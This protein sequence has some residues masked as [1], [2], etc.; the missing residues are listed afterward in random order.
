MQIDGF[1]VPEIN[2]ALVQVAYHQE[3][4]R[5]ES[6][7]IEVEMAYQKKYPNKLGMMSK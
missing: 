2:I 3:A 4:K 5:I 1:L 6:L 7:S